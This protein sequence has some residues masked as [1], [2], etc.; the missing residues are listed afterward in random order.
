[1]PLHALTAIL[2]DYSPV[3][4]PCFSGLLDEPQRLFNMGGPSV[5]PGFGE[6]V[7][8]LGLLTAR[9]RAQSRPL[10]GKTRRA[11]WIQY[12]HCGFAAFANADGHPWIVHGVLSILSCMPCC[13][14]PP[15][16][17]AAV[18]YPPPISPI[19]TIC[20]HTKHPFCQHMD[21][22]KRGLDPFHAATSLPPCSMTSAPA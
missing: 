20:K 12:L 8:P 15:I 3:H 19:P 21:K 9:T 13:H 18:S 6:F 10:A 14:P 16:Y 7:G 22:F 5:P 11:Q 1:M 4:S 17:S 2:T